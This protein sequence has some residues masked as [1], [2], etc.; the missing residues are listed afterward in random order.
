M[1]SEDKDKINLLFKKVVTMGTIDAF[2]FLNSVEDDLK[3]SWASHQTA[4]SDFKPEPFFWKV[5]QNLKTSCNLFLW[6]VI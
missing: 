4:F 5:T 3:S 2:Q 6:N 1:N